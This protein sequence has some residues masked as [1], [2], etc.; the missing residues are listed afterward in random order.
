MVS[1]FWREGEKNVYVSVHI[2]E[3]LKVHASEH[4]A[5]QMG[6]MGIVFPG[7]RK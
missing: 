4:G 5:P 7:S 6:L 1:F 2:V 3:T